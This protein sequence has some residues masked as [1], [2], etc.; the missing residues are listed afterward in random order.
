[1][2]TDDLPH[3]GPETDRLREALLSATFT[4]DGLLDQLGGVAYA[5]LARGETVPALRATRDGTPLATLIR[6]FLLCEEMPADALTDLLPVAGMRAAGWVRP[7]DPDDPGAPLRATVDIRPFAGPDGEDWWVVSDAGCA[8]GGAAGAEGAARDV[9]LG[10]GGASATL[11]QL[12]VDAPAGRALDLGT[13]CGVQ[14]LHLAARG[15]RV[16]VTDVNP[17]ALH[18]ARLT[19]ELSGMPA[20]TARQGSLYEPVRDDER[21]DVVVSNPPFVISPPADPGARLTYRDGGME[22]DALCRSLV[23]GAAD[24]LT[25]GGWCQLLANWEH[26][27][28]EDWRERVATWVPAG[29]DAWIVQREEQDVARYTELWLRDAGAHRG[30]R[31]E[32][33]ARYSHWLDAFAA[34]GTRAIGFGWI[35]LR[36]TGADRPSVVAEE[37]PHA[38]EQP[39]GPEIVRHFAARD[40]LRDLDDAA[41]LA[42]RFVLADGVVQEQIGLPGEEDPEHVVLRQRHGMMRA[43]TVDTV[44]AALV[45]SCDG[46][47]PAGPIVDAIAQ[48]LGEAPGPLREATPATVRSL[49]EQGFLHLAE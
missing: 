42:A 23:E 24:R 49:V 8:I 31:A 28:G 41:L 33:R 11:T 35:T 36:R 30:P 37:W 27:E 43:T 14:A 40:R 10:V 9:V 47:L 18:I 32:Y 21:F 19:L 15:A 12:A 25:D 48:L 3:P 44:G 13:G 26:I 20:P 4:A 6:L 5:A 29:C 17:R 34:R 1:M 16:T 46:T 38:V 22:G 7:T 45:G 2:I 39:L